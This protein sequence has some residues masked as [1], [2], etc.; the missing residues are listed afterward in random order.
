MLQH[1]FKKGF[2]AY[3]L[4]QGLTAAA[5]EDAAVCGEERVVS[6]VLDVAGQQLAQH[7]RSRPGQR[8]AKLLAGRRRRQGQLR[9]VLGLRG[10]GGAV[11]VGCGVDSVWKIRLRAGY[12]LRSALLALHLAQAM[13]LLRHLAQAM[14]LLRCLC[15][16]ACTTTTSQREEPR[17]GCDMRADVVFA[18]SDAAA[19]VA[20]AS[21]A[22]YLT[23]TTTMS[24]RFL[25]CCT[26]QPLQQ[27]QQ[28]QQQ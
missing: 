12:G 8:V 13:L 18:A 10:G 28:Q 7:H 22:V 17:H 15:F 11:Q 20:A 23:C 27:Q 14:L 19:A 3:R 21:W 1:D 24:S 16:L 5:A 4:V 6:Y 25:P 2:R 26:G 9:L